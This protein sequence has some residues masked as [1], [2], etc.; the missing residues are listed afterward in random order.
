MKKLLIFLLFSAPCCFA[1]PVIFTCQGLGIT[2]PTP[3]NLIALTPALQALLTNSTTW[4]ENRIFVRCDP[5]IAIYRFESANYSKVHHARN[6]VYDND[7][8]AAVDL[9]DATVATLPKHFVI[10]YYRIPNDMTTQLPRILWIES[11]P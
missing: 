5:T 2:S 4:Q 6:T 9:D 7:T 10:F 1:R 3:Q 11:L 8:G